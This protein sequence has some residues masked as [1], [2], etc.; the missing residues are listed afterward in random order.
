MATDREI[1]KSN[2]KTESIPYKDRKMNWN[3]ENKNI[4]KEG[5]QKLIADSN[6]DT[7]GNMVNAKTLESQAVS[8]T[9]GNLF[10]QP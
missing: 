7:S 3:V 4:L 9:H 1:V 8:T 5:R 2:S 6:F 10:K